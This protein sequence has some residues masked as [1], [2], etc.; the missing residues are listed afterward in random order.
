MSNMFTVKNGDTVVS[1]G[2][3]YVTHQLRELVVRLLA[4]GVAVL[5]PSAQPGTQAQYEEYLALT[6]QYAALGD[7]TTWF[8]ARTPLAVRRALDKV[9][10]AGHRVRLYYG[11]SETGRYYPEEVDIIGTLGRSAGPMRVCLLLEKGQQGGSAFPTQAVVRIDDLT[12]GATVYQ[13]K[14]FHMPQFDLAPC[15][16]GMGY[17]HEVRVDGEPYARFRSQAKAA[18]F[19]AFI[20]GS[21]NDFKE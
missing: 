19:L 5:H 9:R 13:H 3:E 11:D 7:S 15:A 1:L 14:Q 20:E 21:S 2:V 10:L 18:H 8:D 12:T 4:K 6:K 17:S 16:P